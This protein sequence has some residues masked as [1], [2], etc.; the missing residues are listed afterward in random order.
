LKVPFS[1]ASYWGPTHAEFLWLVAQ[2]SNGTAP[3]QEFRSLMEKA[4]IDH[5]LVSTNRQIFPMELFEVVKEWPD[6]LLLR[7]KV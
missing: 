3:E 7:L 5:I 1:S 4:G 2:K 6:T